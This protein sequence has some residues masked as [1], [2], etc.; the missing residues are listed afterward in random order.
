M[1]QQLLNER[2]VSSSISPS[3]DCDS[4]GDSRGSISS[5]N[6]VRWQL[7]APIR[8][9]ASLCMGRRRAQR[10][11]AQ[12]L[13]SNSVAPRS[14]ARTVNADAVK[15]RVAMAQPEEWRGTRSDRMRAVH[16]PAMARGRR[17]GAHHEHVELSFGCRI[18]EP[19]PQ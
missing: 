7:P 17:G 16:A 19:P 1:S 10:A 2:L 12:A 15:K 3:A 18:E 14:T 6:P 13:I 9:R 8:S 5:P 4:R 11:Q